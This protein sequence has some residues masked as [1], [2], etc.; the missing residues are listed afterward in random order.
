MQQR[1]EIYI[2]RANRKGEWYEIIAPIEWQ[3]FTINQIFKDHWQIPKKLTHDFR[4]HR[5]IK[6]NNQPISWDTKIQAGD[7]IQLHIF[8]EVNDSVIPDYADIQILYEDDHLIIVN[9]P[10]GMDTHP[11]E[12]GQTGTLA[13]AVSYHFLSNGISATA[14]HVHRLDRN[15]TGAVL[16]AKHPLVGVMLDK[17]LTER[18]IKRTYL[19]VVHGILTKKQGCIDAPIGRDRHHPT[20]RRVSKNGQDAITHYKVISNNRNENT[21]LLHLQLDTGRT[22]QIRVHL[23]HLNHPLIG[24][25]LYGGKKSK[26]ARQALHAAKISLHHPFTNELIECYAPFLDEPPIFPDDVTNYLP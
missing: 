1:K 20:K 21:S 24:D 8:Y 4:M 3:Q 18:N 12:L 7:R 26:A 9:K 22:H 23:S 10:S 25:V 19:A 13:N 11:N 5:R 17:M 2:L 15:T 6:I 16:F 14:K